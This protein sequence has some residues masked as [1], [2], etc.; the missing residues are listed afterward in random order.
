MLQLKIH[1]LS[2]GYSGVSE[3]VFNFLLELADRDL[4]PAVPHKGSLGASGDL[5]PL[6][7]MSLPLIGK[8]R[9]WDKAGEKV[10]EAEKVLKKPHVLHLKP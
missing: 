4:I 7:H 10:E 2:L 5:A 9:I 1:G 6:A 3:P 8:G